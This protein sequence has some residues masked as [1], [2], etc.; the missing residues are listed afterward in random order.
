MTGTKFSGKGA[1][2]KAYSLPAVVALA[3]LA[4][5]STPTPPAM[6][7]P[8]VLTMQQGR[9]LVAFAPD[10]AGPA[11]VITQ[12]R[13][14]GVAGSCTL[15][16]EK[17]E[18]VISFQTGFA[19]TNGPADHNLPVT[20]PYFVAIVDPQNDNN[21]LAEQFYTATLKFDG[22][23]S[24]AQLVSKPVKL[25]FPNDHASGHLQVLV[26]FK[27]TPEQQ[28]YNADHPDVRE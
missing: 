7:C 25:D 21:I 20:L 6:F 16:P 12:A 27:L 28:A 13:I 2:M 23:A 10:V 17:K 18:L 3:A 19:A 9:D 24:I 8:E 14:T 1:G 15:H 4:G 5:C 26:G 22:N 11:G